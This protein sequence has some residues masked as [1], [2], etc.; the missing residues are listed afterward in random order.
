MP[1]SL[2]FS[3]PFLPDQWRGS[4]IGYLNL[5]AWRLAKYWDWM[6]PDMRRARLNRFFA[7]SDIPPFKKLLIWIMFLLSPHA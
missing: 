5:A 7:E 1:N 3:K 4:A 6:Y 2:A